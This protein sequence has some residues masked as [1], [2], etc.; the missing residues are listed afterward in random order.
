MT[1]GK[2]NGRLEVPS[3]RPQLIG[4]SHNA[5]LP[6]ARLNCTPQSHGSGQCILKPAL[7]PPHL[8]CVGRLFVAELAAGRI[9]A[10]FQ[11]VQQT[12]QL[13]VHFPP[14]TLPAQIDPVQLPLAPTRVVSRSA[15]CHPTRIRLTVPMKS[16]LAL[17]KRYHNSTKHQPVDGSASPNLHLSF[18]SLARPLE[19]QP[20][21]WGAKRPRQERQ[22]D[23]P[24][25]Y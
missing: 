15:G 17:E 24:P 14:S 21:G 8:H 13:R 25:G 4:P 9:Q 7:G 16:Q 20:V 5:H 6:R 10:V 22:F 18:W 12:A 19:S 1:L 2:F 11:L 23:F 3:P